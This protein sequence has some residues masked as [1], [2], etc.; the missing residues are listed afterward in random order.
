VYRLLLFITIAVTTIGC[1]SNN[2]KL[3]QLV[4]HK[5]INIDAQAKFWVFQNG[6]IKTMSYQQLAISKKDFCAIENYQMQN[7]NFQQQT[8][9][10]IILS[11]PEQKVTRYRL[12]E[13]DHFGFYCNLSGINNKNKDQ[14]SS[15]INRQL[16]DWAQI[17]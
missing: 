4:F 5:T 9:E 1:A 13:D 10:T 3:H 14:L 8:P 11:T 6:E 16:G 2:S 7:L 17:K 15:Y 12:V